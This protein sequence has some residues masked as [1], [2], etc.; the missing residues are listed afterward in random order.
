MAG[1]LHSGALKDPPRQGARKVRRASMDAT[2]ADSASQLPGPDGVMLEFRGSYSV[3]DG[4]WAN[5]GWLQELPDFVTR[6][7]WDNAVVI[8]P[9]PEVP[10]SP[11]PVT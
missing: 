11:R 10:G 3:Y 9:S 6:L 7:T 8:G 1:N 4:R 5:N 2:L